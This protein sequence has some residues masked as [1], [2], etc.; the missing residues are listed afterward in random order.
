MVRHPEEVVVLSI[1]DETSA[2]DTAKVIRDSGLADEVYLGDA[3][4]RGPRCAS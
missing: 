3:D 1:Q 4:A 2:A